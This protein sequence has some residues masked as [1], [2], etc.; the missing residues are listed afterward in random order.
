MPP[1]VSLPEPSYLHGVLQRLATRG[2]ILEVKRWSE[3]GRRASRL[4]Y[5]LLTQQQVVGDADLDWGLGCLVRQ[6]GSGPWSQEESRG[7]D[8]RGSTGKSGPDLPSSPNTLSANS[9]TE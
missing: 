1:K 9:G 7:G 2:A 6:L 5:Q 3:G 4:D 8:G